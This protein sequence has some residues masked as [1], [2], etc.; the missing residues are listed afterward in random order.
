MVHHP[1]KTRMFCRELRE[2]VHIILFA[3]NIVDEQYLVND[4]SHNAADMLIC[5]YVWGWQT[6][7][8][9][10]Y[11]ERRNIFQVLLISHNAQRP[12][13]H[14]YPVL[15]HFSYKQTQTKQPYQYFFT[16]T[17]I[18]KGDKKFDG[19]LK[20]N[21]Y[22]STLTIDSVVSGLIWFPEDTYQC[23][24]SG[25]LELNRCLPKS[26]KTYGTLLATG[27]VWDRLWRNIF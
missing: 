10:L 12:Q 2:S 25:S 3:L 19:T 16:T 15:L 11:I 20:R 23:I 22:R 9:L 5:L 4:I 26:S 6:F 13:V 14:T 24:K 18:S 21:R 27:A 17:R 1:C 7:C 8:K